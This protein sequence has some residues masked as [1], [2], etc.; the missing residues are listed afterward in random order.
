MEHVHDTRGFYRTITVDE[1]A[2]R[3]AAKMPKYST[4]TAQFNLAKS[5]DVNSWLLI[6]SY[7]LIFGL[8][9]YA[10]LEL[11]RRYALRNLVRKSSLNCDAVDLILASFCITQSL[12]LF[13]SGNG[14]AFA[15]VI[16]ALFSYLATMI[17]SNDL[18]RQLVSQIR[19]EEPIDS[20]ADVPSDHWLGNYMHYF[21]FEGE[22]RWKLI[23][24]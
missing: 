11:Y 4:D 12:V 6:V 1:D 19:L 13:R 8:L 9:F 10:A 2:H 23:H 18:R 7:L 17:Y 3:L 20:I 14:G 16:W 21:V 15:I 24:K 22:R 5:V